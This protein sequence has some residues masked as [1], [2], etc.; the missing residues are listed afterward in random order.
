MVIADRVAIAVNF[1][2]ENYKEYH[3][4]IIFIGAAL[5]SLQ[6]FCDF[7]GGMAI[8]RGVAQIVGINLP[9]NFKQPFFATSIEDFWRR[10]H[11][12]LGS[13]MRDYVLYPISLSKTFNRIGR[14]SRKILGN[15]FGKQLPTFLAMLITFFLVGIWHG[16]DWK[17]IA[18]G[19]YNGVLIITGILIGP[20]LNRFINWARIKQDVFSWKLLMSGATFLLTTIGRYFSR[21]HNLWTAQNMLG[22]TFFHFNPW[23]LFDGTLLKLG[24]SIENILIIV[25]SIS[26]L[27]VV[28]LLHEKGVSIRQKISQQNLYFRWLIYIVAIFSTV[29]FGVYGLEYQTTDFIYRGF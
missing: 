16:P 18:Y 12:T 10:W 17:F 20:L 8:A 19:L 7:S 11:I 13:W 2:F 24:L 23:V 6:V 27:L 28:G 9:K 26:L 22:W 4:V 1:I 29:I 5:Y 14:I 21:A 15:K 3:G 25:I